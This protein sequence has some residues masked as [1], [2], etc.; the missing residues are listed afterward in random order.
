MSQR[1]NRLIAG[2]FTAASL[3][4]AIPATV[5]AATIIYSVTL[6]TGG[7]ENYSLPKFDTQN[8]Q[9]ELDSVDFRISNASTSMIVQNPQPSTGP[10]LSFL[11]N[12]KVG[13]TSTDLG[14]SVLP[15]LETTYTS[16]QPSSNL[17]F[18]FNQSFA[19]VTTHITSGLD[20][21]TNNNPSGPSFIGLNLAGGTDILNTPIP[22][23][24]TTRDRAV[25]TFTISYNSKA[26]APAVPEPATWAMMLAG[27]GLVGASM[28]C[29]SQSPSLAVRARA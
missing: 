29:R 9:F 15:G 24:A 25:A 11:L 26:A 4:V 14:P 28:R 1:R 2:I 20:A 21:F 5:D 8:G 6:S 13:V 17:S 7:F 22:L 27:F 3:V 16:T 12:S 19:P 10:D 23:G 18:T